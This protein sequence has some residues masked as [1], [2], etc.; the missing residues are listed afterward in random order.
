MP[1]TEIQC[2]NPTDDLMLHGRKWMPEGQIKALL[3]IVHGLGEHSGRYDHMANYMNAQGIGVIALDMHGHGLSADKNGKKRGLCSGMDLMHGD[4][5]GL[6]ETGK[7]T[8]PN[9]PQFLMGHSMGGGIVLSYMLENPDAKLSGVIA[10]APLIDSPDRP[11]NA[12]ISIMKF[13]TKVAPNFRLK[14]KLEGHKIST[15]KSEQD[16]Y[17]ADPLNHLYLGGKL[18]LAMFETGDKLSMGAKNFP[19]LPLL[20]THGTQD[21]LTDFGASQAFAHDVGAKF[22]AYEN[23]GHEVHNDLHRDKVYADLVDFILAN[24]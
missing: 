18:A 16:K 3:M 10:Q 21:L 8:A 22:I 19:K 2:K 11:P 24:S 4:V 17:E 9:A 12:L 20:V 23:S 6:I 7:W 15:L 13:I 1:H 14:A 5:D